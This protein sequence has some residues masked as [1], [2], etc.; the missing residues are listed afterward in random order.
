MGSHF[1][2]SAL[3]KTTILSQY[4]TE[5]RRWAITITVLSAISFPIASWIRVSFSGSANAV[6]SSRITIGESF[7]I[8][9]ASSIL[10]V[11]PPDK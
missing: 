9:L 2:N 6:A 10:W 5:R 11:S 3:F 7:K 1:L 4:S 8:A